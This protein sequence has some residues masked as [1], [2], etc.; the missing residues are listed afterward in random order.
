MSDRALETGEKSIVA[1]EEEKEDGSDADT[2]EGEERN[3]KGG[4]K[5]RGEGSMCLNFSIL[6]HWRTCLSYSVL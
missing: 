2:E 6:G 4:G 5:M 3:G 1:E